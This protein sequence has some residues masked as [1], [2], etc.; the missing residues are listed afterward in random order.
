MMKTILMILAALLSNVL[1][2]ESYVISNGQRIVAPAGCSIVSSSYGTAVAPAGCS[3]VSSS[4]GTAVAPAGSSIVSSSNGTTIAPA[5][6]SVVSSSSGTAVRPA[7]YGGSYSAIAYD[8]NVRRCGASWNWGNQTLANKKAVESCNRADCKVVV[9][10]QSMCT[11]LAA[12]KNVTHDSWWARDYN[13][14]RAR[15]IALQN[16]ESHYGNCEIICDTCNH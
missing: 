13:Q 4:Y 8:K 6:S 7:Q 16:C 15:T 10:A 9:T 14:R 5:G 11:V 2:A 12:T 3:I 1:G